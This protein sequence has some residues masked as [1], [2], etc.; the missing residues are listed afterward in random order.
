MA[1][2]KDG[3]WQIVNG[4]EKAPTSGGDALTK[5]NS[6][7]DRALAVVVLLVDPTLLYLLGEPT[8]PVEVWKTLGRNSSKKKPGRIALI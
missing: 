2:M 4:S 3:L 5:F 1:L 8:D 7:N 6:R